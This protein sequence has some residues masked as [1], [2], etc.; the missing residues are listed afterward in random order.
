MVLLLSSCSFPDN[1]TQG[2]GSSAG[3]TDTVDTSDPNEI[4]NNNRTDQIKTAITF[5]RREDPEYGVEKIV[6]LNN[7]ELYFVFSDDARGQK[8]QAEYNT[9]NYK[10]AEN[11]RQVY[12]PEYGNGGF[13]EFIWINQNGTLTAI[14]GYN[15]YLQADIV[16]ITDFEG[17]SNIV[18]VISVSSQGGSDIEAIDAQGQHHD[19]YQPLYV[20]YENMTLKY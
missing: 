7:N 17:L 18:D 13:K 9:K 19:L 10:V 15:L 2:N 8:L 14:K 1:A 12:A 16:Y 6:L 20:N 3:A 11:V 5:N 4:I